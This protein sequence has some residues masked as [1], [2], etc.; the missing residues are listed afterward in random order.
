MKLFL[1]AFPVPSSE[2][3]TNGDESGAD[4]TAKGRWEEDLSQGPSSK[5]E[6]TRTQMG[7]LTLQKGR[8]MERARVR[9]DSRL[10]AR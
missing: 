4:D 7:Q 5:G 1:F 8:Q 10:L 9:V 3:I 2:K 6:D